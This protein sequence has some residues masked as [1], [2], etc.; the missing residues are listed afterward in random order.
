MWRR[1][2]AGG[3]QHAHVRV[4]GERVGAQRQLGH[5]RASAAWTR[6]AGGRRGP[7]SPRRASRRRRRGGR[8]GRS[9][10]PDP[11]GHA[12]PR[13]PVSMAAPTIEVTIP[14]PRAIRIRA[15]PQRSSRNRCPRAP[16]AAAPRRAR[17]AA[18]AA[19]RGDA[20]ER[21]RARLRGHHGARRRRRRSGLAQRLLRAVR[22]QAD[23]F[24]ALCDEAATEMLDALLAHRGATTGSGAALRAPRCYLRWWQERPAFSRALPGRAAV[25]RPAR[26]RAAR[27]PVPRFRE[28]F[29]ALGALGA[30]RAA[31]AAAAGPDRR[32]GCWSWR[33]PSSSPRRCAPGRVDQLVDL[34][35]EL[36]RADGAAACLL[37]MVD[38]AAVV[39]GWPWI[40]DAGRRPCDRNSGVSHGPIKRVVSG[41]ARRGQPGAR[42]VEPAI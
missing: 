41:A 12:A 36:R 28:M 34:E 29:E 37:E 26:D 17:V 33:S 42:V 13:A 1:V 23:C 22:R 14:P 3:Q 30:R 38:F 16:Q 39:P 7:G 9:C 10:R 2:V 15:C 5:A 11:R 4:G 8:G 18:R 25:G 31:R 27:P 20:R 21:R 32:R 40:V 6:R 19:A 35:D 24:L